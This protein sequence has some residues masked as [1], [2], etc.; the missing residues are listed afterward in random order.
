MYPPGGL[1]LRRIFVPTLGSLGTGY[2]LWRYFP[3]GCTAAT[4]HSPRANRRC[5]ACSHAGPGA[6]CCQPA[7]RGSCCYAAGS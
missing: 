4:A 3:R 5:E 1:G 7:A 6:C 2:L